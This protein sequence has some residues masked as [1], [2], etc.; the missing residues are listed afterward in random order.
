MGSA[1]G[2]RE[3]EEAGAKVF[4]IDRIRVVIVDSEGMVVQDNFS[5][6]A[7]REV[8]PDLDG[9]STTIVDL[10]TNQPVGYAYVDVNRQFLTTESHGFLRGLLTSSA[11]GGLLIAAIALLLAAWLAKRITAP[12]TALTQ[13]TQAIARHGDTT[14][15]P[16]TSSDELGL[17][18]MS[19]AFNQMTTTLQTQ[20]SLRRRLINDVAHELNTPLS[21]IQLEAHGLRKGLQTPTRAAGQIIQEV[22]MLHNLVRDL[23]WLAETDSGEQ[24]ITVK[25]YSIYQLLTAEVA[26]WQP[27]AQTRQIALSL[28]LLSELPKLTLDPMRMGQALGNV[29]NN[30]FQ[31]TGAGGQI[32]LAAT[33]ETGKGLEI[34]VTD[35]GA[36]IELADLPHI[37]NR[38]YRTDQSRNRRTGGMGLGLD[39]ARAIIEAHNGVIAVTSDGLEQGTA[40]RFDLP[41]D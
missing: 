27:Q 26:R 3:G 20:R 38:F 10:R 8:A 41:L 25:P 4:Y 16:V 30:A 1:K 9:Q 33:M 23:N 19:A 5:L 13:A 14:L 17:G 11:I 31:H 32:T 28:Q 18:Q 6:R 40:V 39:I 15:I 12:V 29:I 21:I 22:N 2:N 34:S 7:S 35:D 24:R 37:C 36:G